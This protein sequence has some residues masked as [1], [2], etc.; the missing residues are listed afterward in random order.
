MSEHWQR[1]QQRE[2]SRERD[3]TYSADNQRR[4][5]RKDHTPVTQLSPLQLYR[6]QL[7]GQVSNPLGRSIAELEEEARQEAE[8]ARQR[9]E[10]AKKP[11]NFAQDGITPQQIL[12]QI[13]NRQD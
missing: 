11:R 9:A 10:N 3:K 2:N 7:T 13:H 6:R 1:R 8:I 12:N 5:P 4:R